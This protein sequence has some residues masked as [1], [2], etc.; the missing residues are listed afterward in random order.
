MKCYVNIEHLSHN[1]SGSRKKWFTDGVKTYVC[2]LTPAYF[3]WEKNTKY[4]DYNGY[5][6]YVN[7]KDV[8]LIE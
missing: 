8:E 2:S 6:G 1:P 4:N 3:I 7:C 5:S